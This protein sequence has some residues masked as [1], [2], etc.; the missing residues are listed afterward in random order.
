MRIIIADKTETQELI[1]TWH[2]KVAGGTSGL[3]PRPCDQ[4]S[5]GLS[6]HRLQTMDQR[7]VQ[8]WDAVQLRTSASSPSSPTPLARSFCISCSLILYPNFLT[9]STLCIPHRPEIQSCRERGMSTTPGNFL[10]KY[11]WGYRR[12]L[13]LT[14]LPFSK[15]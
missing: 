7:Q 2:S 4:K 11:L 1:K 5:S 10:R 8:Q 12:G 3:K 15:R 9:M 13:K 6:P 14:Y